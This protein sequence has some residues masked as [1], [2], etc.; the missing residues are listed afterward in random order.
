MN[1]SLAIKSRDAEQASGII[2]KPEI[3]MVP[4]WNSSATGAGTGL[5]ETGTGTLADLIP[6]LHP[7][8]TA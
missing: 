2:P 8:R 1:P 6:G 4:A 7:L 3:T 5:G